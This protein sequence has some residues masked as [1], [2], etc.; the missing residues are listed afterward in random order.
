M[1]YQI[2]VGSQGKNVGIEIVN[3]AGRCVAVR[4]AK[5]CH[6]LRAPAGWAF[7]EEVI[8]FVQERGVEVIKII[9]DDK[10]FACGMAKFLKLAVPFD[11]GFGQQ[12]HLP[13]NYWKI[14]KPETRRPIR[15]VLSEEART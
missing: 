1:K 5:P 7:S 6:M 15:P 3:E 8:K 13:L 14:T 4:R 11:R 12:R 2:Q 10:V 9:C